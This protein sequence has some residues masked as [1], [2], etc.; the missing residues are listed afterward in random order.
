M[1]DPW[2]DDALEDV[3]VVVD[4]NSADFDYQML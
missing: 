2:V 4:A 3:A 1:D